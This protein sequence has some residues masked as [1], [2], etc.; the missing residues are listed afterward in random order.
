MQLHQMQET[1]WYYVH[2][3]PN[4]V[5]KAMHVYIIIATYV[6]VLFM[7]NTLCLHMCDELTLQ[8]SETALPCHVK[9]SGWSHISVGCGLW[10][11]ELH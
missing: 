1:T 10:S 11:K 2:V 6:H 4:K 9:Q 8:A 7:S 5:H 3:T